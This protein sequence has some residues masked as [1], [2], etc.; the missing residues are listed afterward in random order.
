MAMAPAVDASRWSANP[1]TAA[2]AAGW[3]ACATL[4]PY[5]RP[6]SRPCTPIPCSTAC[7]RN[8]RRSPSRWLASI[9]LF[10]YRH[11]VTRPWQ[12]VVVFP[13]AGVDIGNLTPYQPLLTCG[14]LRRVYLSDLLGR[15][16]L[17]VA[18]RLA[19]L[20]VLDTAAVPAEARALLAAPGP[21][22]D[23]LE[24][25]DLVETI[26]VYKFPHLTREEIRAMLHLP[27]TELKKT[28]FYQE[29]FGEGR[30][31]GR[32][33]GMADLL[34]RQ[35][36]AKFGP[37][38]AAQRHRLQQADTETLLGWSERLLS[39]RRPDDLFGDGH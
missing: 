24:R 34:Q 13:Q 15:D 18:A 37:L 38:S 11:R 30:E 27:E 4:A 28:R 31:E 14:L 12:A 32:H 22:R 21:Q 19:R 1:P 7:F 35:L 2:L 26:L 6:R 3:A 5:P 8:A 23:A 36:A 17:S 25:L 16:D 29:V 33:T 10:L 20:I 9:F 39:A